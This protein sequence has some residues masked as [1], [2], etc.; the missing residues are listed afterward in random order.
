VLQFDPSASTPRIG[1]GNAIE[2]WMVDLSRVNVAEQL[3]LKY[4]DAGTFPSNLMVVDL[5]DAE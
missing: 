1:A 2:R 4:A 3:L 5:V